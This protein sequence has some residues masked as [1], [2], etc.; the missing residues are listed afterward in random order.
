MD[1]L[2]IENETHS[3]PL[4]GRPADALSTDGFGGVDAHRADRPAV[5]RDSSASPD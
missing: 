3:S 4:P 5:R 2:R 1:L